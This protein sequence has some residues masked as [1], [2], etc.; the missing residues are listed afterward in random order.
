MRTG[1]KEP[2]LLNSSMV[3]STVTSEGLGGCWK[4]WETLLTLKA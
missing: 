3:S 2:N 4:G 1:A